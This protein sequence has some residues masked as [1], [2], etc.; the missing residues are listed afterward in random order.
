MK[1]GLVL[2]AGGVLGGAWLTGGLHA[3]AKETDWDPGSAEYIVGTSAGSMI[4]A[5]LAAGVPPW[6]MV[7]HSRGESFAGLNGPDG[8]PAAEADRSAGA[9]FRVHKG[10][11]MIGP[12]S[13]RMAITA[14]SNPMRH[15]PLQMLAGWL[16]AGFISTD[17]LK[18]VVSRAVPGSWVDHPNYWAVACDYQNGR[19]VPFGRLD[20]P[21]AEIADAVAASCA[22]PGFYRPVRIG[23]RRYVDGG[24]C[25]AS[26]LDLVAGRGLDLVICLN[27]LSSAESGFEPFAPQV[28]LSALSRRANGRRLAHE[29]RKVR[30]F[31]TEVVTIQPT[32]EDHAVMG[33]NLMSGSRRQQVIETAERTVAEQ[34]RRPEL[35]ALLAALPK[36]E[37]HKIRRPEGPPSSWPPL[38][39]ALRGAAR[40]DARGRAA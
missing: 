32:D 24:V 18:E 34:L 38:E 36:G 28:W 21:R 10:I 22:I 27:P 23:R 15:T 25:S 16:P 3:L 31:G 17:S 9:L 7:A 6:F 5:L 26:N 39:P 40:R 13:L 33:H 4:G 12:G 14:L 35:R 37:P 11:P 8:R 1:V 30:R 19:R 2:G 29:E 20:S